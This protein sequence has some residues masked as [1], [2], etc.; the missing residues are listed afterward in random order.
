MEVDLLPADSFPVVSW[1]RDY[2]M[3]MFRWSGNATEWTEYAMR[4]RP[5]I[6]A[7]L[8]APGAGDGAPAA[9]LAMLRK[10]SGCEIRLE[11]DSLYGKMERFLVF[12]RGDSGQPSNAAMVLALDL[13]SQ[14]FRAQ[15]QKNTSSPGSASTSAYQQRGFSHSAA[16]TAASA[17]AV[18]LDDDDDDVF[19]YGDDYD[20]AMGKGSFKGGKPVGAG[21]GRIQRVV[22]IPQS[23]VGLIAGKNGKKLYS[24]RK[25]SGAFMSLVSKSRK[26]AAK[27]TISGLP[28][29]VEIALTLV[30]QALLEPDSDNPEAIA[31]AAAIFPGAMM[32]M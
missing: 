5:D 16:A 27:L 3:H 1:L 19:N 23:A 28:N 4:L 31:A 18:T 21:D 32:N 20:L 14:M 9:A 8:E 24:M 12:V 13:A 7:Y 2:E 6:A 17:A 29:D 25:K 11:T 22:D 30:K 15:L 26:T 10:R